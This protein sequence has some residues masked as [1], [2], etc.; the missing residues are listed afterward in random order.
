MDRIGDSLDELA[1]Y[2]RNNDDSTEVIIVDDGSTD[3]TPALVEDRRSS[4]EHLRLIRLTHGGKARAVLAGLEVATGDIVGFMDAD[5]ATPLDELSNVFARIE[6]SAAVVIGS[7]EEP[8]SIRIGEPG[9]RHV[10]GRAFN[11]IVR[12]LLLPTIHDSQCG[13]KFMTRD[14]RDQILPGMRLYSSQSQ[15][16]APQVTA[17]DVEL[18]YI[19]RQRDL[20]IVA[21]PVTWSYGTH[22]KVNPIRD[23]FQNIRDVGRVWLNGKRGLYHEE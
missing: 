20:K 6:G 17:F 22:S 21:I 16:E 8:G 14:A 5:L 12:T 9:Y 10:M 11:F 1:D 15:L 2:V 3:N 18:L 7:R 13:F 4:F 19:A 23:T